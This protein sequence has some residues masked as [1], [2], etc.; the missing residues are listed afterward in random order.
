MIAL[1]ES[2]MLSAISSKRRLFNQRQ[3]G[4]V[5]FT[6]L[7]DS[8]NMNSPPPAVI[9]MG[10][11]GCGKS[12]VGQAVVAELGWPLL[13]GDAYHAASSIAKMQAGTALNDDD[14]SGWLDRLVE[15]LQSD[16]GAQGV[17]LTCS[18]LKRKYRDHLRTARP[19]GQVRFVFLDLTFDEA[20]Q[21]VQARSGHFFSPELVANQFATLERPNREEGVLT[22]D[23]TLPLA[24]IAGQIQQWLRP[25]ALGA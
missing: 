16:T 24:H 5:F 18:S 15:L 4:S 13:E 11:S 7:M 22:V 2:S 1:T 8:A 12:T 25:G 6:R 17:V 23:A 19:A 14:R 10:V 9:V 20:L 3:T 21:R